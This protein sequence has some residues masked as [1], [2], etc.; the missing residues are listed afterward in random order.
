VVVGVVGV[1]GEALVG[2]GWWAPPPPPPPPPRVLVGVL[3]VAMP[4]AV[5]LCGV[6]GSSLGYEVIL[7]E[8]WQRTRSKEGKG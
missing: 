1:I 4:K 2:G 8:G 3:G 7:K 5:T 6:S